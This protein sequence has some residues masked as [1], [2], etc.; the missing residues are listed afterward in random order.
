MK[1]MKGFLAA[2]MVAVLPLAPAGANDAKGCRDLAG[3]KRFE[4]SAL[5]ECDGRNFAEYRLPTGAA[6]D[7]DH[8]SKRGT[9]A[10]QLDLEGRLARTLYIVPP[11]P[12]GAEVFR[13]Y[14]MELRDKGFTALYEARGGE[15]GFWMPKVFE[16]DGPGG[17]LLGYNA[18]ETRYIAA[19]K[20]EGGVKTH[21]AILVVEY[22]DGHHS[23]FRPEKGQVVVRIDML[24]SGELKDQMVTV[25][26]AEIAR[27]IGQDG[28]I[29]LYGLNF[30]FN[31]ATLQPDSGPTLE[32]N[33]KFLRANPSQRVHVVGH[34]DSVGSLDSNQKLSQARAATV[35]AALIKQYSIASSRLRPAGL[36]PLAP[37]ASNETEEGR[38]KNRRVEL[39]PQ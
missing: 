11:G 6:Q 14:R 10:S 23:R 36:G 35:V 38:A 27:S 7:Y 32:E 19:S 2:A 20:D 30:D 39:L 21:L 18:P 16:N 37:V 9:F 5:V 4:T 12:S 28:R 25:S 31:K 29:A 15:L 26:A 34:T 22:Q 1:K 24:E 17:Q 13:N 8:D 33:A 3:L